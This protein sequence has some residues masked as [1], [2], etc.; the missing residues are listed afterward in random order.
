[1]LFSAFLWPFSYALKRTR[2]RN[3]PTILLILFA[4]LLGKGYGAFAYSQETGLED[5]G[6]S[7]RYKQLIVKADHFMQLREYEMAIQ[8][9]NNALKEKAEDSYALYKIS[10]CE[11]Y[12]ERD[13][14]ASNESNRQVKFQHM[15]E[16]GNQLMNERNFQDAI[17][18]FLVAK[19]LDPEKE[20]V[21]IKIDQ[22]KKGLE[23]QRSNKAI[24]S[25]KN[26]VRQKYDEKITEADELFYADDWAGSI[27]KYEE[28][29]RILEN[30]QYPMLQI[31]KAI[32][33]IQDFQKKQEDRDRWTAYDKA[34]EEADEL[35]IEQRYEECIRKYEEANGYVKN[36]YRPRIKILLAKDL[37]VKRAID[38]V[39]FKYSAEVTTADEYREREEYEKAIE[40]YNKAL[41]IYPLKQ[42][43]ITK[44]MQCEDLIR[45]RE[46]KKKRDEFNEIMKDALALVRAENFIDAGEKYIEAQKIY[47]LNTHVKTMLR[48]CEKE[49]AKID[50]KNRKPVNYFELFKK[51]EQPKTMTE[52]A[53]GGDDISRKGGSGKNYSF[54]ELYLGE[55]KKRAFYKA[56]D[57]LAQT[58]PPGVTQEIKSGFRKSIVRRVVIV[59]NQ[60]DEFLKVEHDWGGV[61]HFKNGVAVTRQIWEKETGSP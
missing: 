57:T 32:V 56:I 28:A 2:L 3:L 44:I 11:K 49:Q 9:Y 20:Y 45:R 10:I 14:K 22:A 5:S 19:Q 60:G 7:P 26:A 35:L 15:M 46:E 6:G 36:Q 38:S 40:V 42:Y 33:L 39:D 12:L 53:G 48:V 37:I 30:E 34:I 54:K 24:A 27:G 23:K 47:P 1:L 41:E 43:P 50:K 25:E 55:T 16:V 51:G 61:Y 13:Q 31:K 21:Q 4:E 8:E 17:D 29:S 52:V 59:E 58:Y 18:S